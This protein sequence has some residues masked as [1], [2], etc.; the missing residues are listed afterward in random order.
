MQHAQYSIDIE[1]DLFSANLGPNMESV[2]E[3]GAIC[4]PHLEII[5]HRCDMEIVMV[6]GRLPSG[7]SSTLY[8]ANG[9]N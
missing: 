8:L 4:L 6:D 7:G 3:L 9:Q 2:N 5:Q 1:F